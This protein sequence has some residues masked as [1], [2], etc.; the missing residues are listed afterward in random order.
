MHF[1]VILTSG[2]SKKKREAGKEITVS[3]VY[4]NKTLQN[5]LLLENN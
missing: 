5:V 1:L 2:Q 4:E 3:V